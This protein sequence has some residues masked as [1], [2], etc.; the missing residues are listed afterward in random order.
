MPIYRDDLPLMNPAGTASPDKLPKAQTG[1]Y[2]TD[3]PKCLTSAYTRGRPM[4]Y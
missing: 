2:A 1:M 3:V 4:F